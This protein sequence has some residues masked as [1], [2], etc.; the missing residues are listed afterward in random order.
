M[1]FSSAQTIPNNTRR[2]RLSLGVR[3]VNLSLVL[4]RRNVAMTISHVSEFVMTKS[5]EAISGYRPLLPDIRFPKPISKMI[6]APT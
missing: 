3:R 4:F 5:K 1:S 6:A 2:S